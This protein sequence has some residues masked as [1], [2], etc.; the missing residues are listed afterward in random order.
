MGF[1]TKGEAHPLYAP[2]S[3]GV[4]KL[5]KTAMEVQTTHPWSCRSP[6]VLPPW[7]DFCWNQVPPRSAPGPAAPR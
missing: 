2:M 3:K 1:L 4:L 7:M 5:V 6:Q